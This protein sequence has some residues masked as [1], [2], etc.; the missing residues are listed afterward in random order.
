MPT[1]W[2]IT[3]TFDGAE[4]RRTMTI[5]AESME[6]AMLYVQEQ[7]SFKTVKFVRCG[8]VLPKIHIANDSMAKVV[9]TRP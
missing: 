8:M 4:D 9:R 3:F 2:K 6:N 7:F 1:F 5:L